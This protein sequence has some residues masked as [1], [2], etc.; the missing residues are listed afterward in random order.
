MEKG[1]ENGKWKWKFISA[2]DA[3]LP[4]A[5]CER[6]WSKRILMAAVAVISVCT[7]VILLTNT[8][9]NIIYENFKKIIS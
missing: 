3:L 4:F 8:Y 6:E 2:P 7:V 9:F 1:M 5:R